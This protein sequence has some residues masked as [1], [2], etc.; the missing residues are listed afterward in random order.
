MSDFELERSPEARELAEDALF[1]LLDALE[2]HDLSLVVLGGLVPELLT[3][4]QGDEIPAH[5]GTTDIDIHISFL[6]DPEGDLS[7]L[8]TA[9]ESIDAE[10]DPKIDGWRWLIPIADTRVKV[11]FL[12]DLED[13]PAGATILLPGCTRV[14]AANLRGTGFVARDWVEETIERTVDGKTVVRR[15]RFVGLQGYMMAKS[16]AA[17]YR[18]EEKDYYDLVH[19]L[20][21]NR[22]G[23]PEQAATKLT[24]GQF[25][26]DVRAARSVFR[27]IEARFTDTSAYGAQS[28]ARQAL[29]VQPEADGAQLAQD[30]VGAIAEFIT[31][32]GLP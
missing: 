21:F 1:Q 6:A 16:Y 4:G 11:E 9:L 13:Q 27:E 32:L 15:A 28:Y 23:G 2:G 12:C 26:D 5:L 19:V 14:K 8:E 31:T 3:G 18:G 30:A 17:R 7:A 20:L 24:Q 22:A 25:G 10:P 29:R